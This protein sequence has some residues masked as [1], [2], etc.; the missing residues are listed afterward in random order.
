MKITIDASAVVA[1]Y[2]RALRSLSRL[3]GFS[4]KDTL[5]AEA[6]VILK[7]WAGRTIPATQATADRRSRRA[8][9]RRMAVASG[10]AKV[11]INMGIKKS[12]VIGRV[13][14]RRGGGGK[15][16]QIGQMTP[17]LDGVRW[18][19]AGGGKTWGAYSSAIEPVLDVID[20]M[21]KYIERGRN[22][23]GLGRQSIVQCADDLGIDLGA[24]KG[25]G[26]LSAN[27]VDKARRAIASNGQR[28]KNGGGSE[29]GDEVKC[30]LEIRNW[31]PANVRSG[32]ARHLLSIFNGRSKSIE[33]AYS[34][35]AFD[36]IKNT[37]KQFPN[38]FVRGMDVATPTSD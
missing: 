27:S 10:P 21:P 5:R 16:L 33:T 17:A 2:Q 18:F 36:S 19:N 20:S 9:G 34:K 37:A 8:L 25:G 4:Q 28:Y 22:A 32:M 14:Y 3:S 24:V 38:L 31:Y 1:E 29:A 6:G 12:A 35:G 23:I 26:S 11:T 13:W 30:T 15:F 7:T